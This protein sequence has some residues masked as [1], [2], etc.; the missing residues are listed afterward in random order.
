[1]DKKHIYP[2]LEWYTKFST[3]L[4]LTPRCPF[5]TVK[6]C[7]RY[8][9]SLSLLG[10]AGSTKID[11]KE[12]KKLLKVWEKNE[13]WP[14]TLEQATS[15]SGPDNDKKHFW[16][17]CPEILFDRFGLFASDIDFFAEN[18][19]QQSMHTWL[20]KINSSKKDWRWDFFRVSPLH[21]S[22]CPI[23]API[24]ET[25]QK[26]IPSLSQDIIELKPGFGGLTINV[27][28]LISR[29][30]NYISTGK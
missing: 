19:D 28:A 3:S 27:K 17:F 5:S 12:D 30:V 4:G 9:Q 25:V 22:Q 7:P 13:L 16:K 18:Q 15:V 29:I 2:D 11:L 14:L 8:Y 24:K 1:M 20:K 23:Y 10:E 21:Y 26:N 6:R